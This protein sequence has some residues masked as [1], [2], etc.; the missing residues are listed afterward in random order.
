M[1]ALR[2]PVRRSRRATLL[3]ALWDIGAPTA[4]YY[5][6]RAAGVSVFSALL[7]GAILPALS[8]A[9]QWI[10]RRHLDALGGFGAG[11]M[12]MSLIAS[13]IGG[14]PRFLL[15][16]DGWVTGVGGLWF[17]GSARARRPLV[18]LSAQP[19]FDGRFRSD[20]TPWDVLWEHEPKF[21]RIWRVS[22]VI[23]GVTMLGDGAAR[24]A[25]AYTLPIDSVPAL[26]AL[27]WPITIAFLQVV[28]GAY[29]EIA[30]LWRITSGRVRTGDYRAEDSGAPVAGPEPAEP[31]RA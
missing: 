1:T 13:V 26:S 21:R 3:I 5:G 27:L 11:M 20:G 17:A 4:L 7:A 19:L 22:T 25:M 6:L 12:L 10:R 2:P 8:T 14:S 16:R 15:A 24:I 31:A 29:Y 28:N 9:A 18:F 30:G 23:W